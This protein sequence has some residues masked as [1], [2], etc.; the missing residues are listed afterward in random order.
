MHRNRFEHVPL[1]DS[2]E[3]CSTR[4]GCQRIRSC[5][6]RSEFK[7]APPPAS[8]LHVTNRVASEPP[9]DITAT[10]AHR[11]TMPA[12]THGSCDE[13]PPDDETTTGSFEEHSLVSH[14]F[15]CTSALRNHL[16]DINTQP[17]LPV[18]EGPETGRPAFATT[19]ADSIKLRHSLLSFFSTHIWFGNK[20][21]W[22]DPCASF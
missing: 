7:P 17:F 10:C 20:A 3:G 18:A 15:H 8:L 21:C 2:S 12:P 16:I 19:R 1:G 13:K 6:C 4:A 14:Q 22:P 5:S 11:Y 9:A